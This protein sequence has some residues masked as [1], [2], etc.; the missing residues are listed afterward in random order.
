MWNR[1]IVDQYSSVGDSFLPIRTARLVVR[2]FKLDDAVTFAGYRNDPDVAQFQDW[3][4]PFT[5]DVAAAFVDA[6]RDVSAP[7]AGD[8]VQLAI[9]HDRQLAG[10]IGVGLDRSGRLAT[11]GYTLRLDKQGHGFAL[12]AVGAVVDH[13]FGYCDVHR[14]AATID[15]RNLPSKR[16][17]ERLGFRHEGR[18]IQAV[19]V[20]GTW[21]DDDLYALLA[22][23]RQRS[24]SRH[25]GGSSR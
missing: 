13:L 11:I 21:C 1:T 8:W 15:P 19:F 5:D 4:L 20:R 9:E 10:D 16:L 17:L 2:A 18:A 6:Q 25:V 12:E 3:D 22:I 23:D 24:L 14:I 7:V